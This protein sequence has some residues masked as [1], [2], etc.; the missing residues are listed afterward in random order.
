MIDLNLITERQLMEMEVGLLQY[1]YIRSHFDLGDNEDFREVFT[2]FYLSSQGKMRQED[3]RNPFFEKLFNTEPNQNLIELVQYLYD[4]L[5]LSMYE[6]SFATKLLHTI[7]NNSPIYDSKVYEYLKREEDVDF[8]DIQSSRRKKNGRLMNKLERIEH[9]WNEL[10]EWYGSFLQSP[11]GREW[12]N[13]F[14]EHFP[15][16]SHINNVKKIDF[17]IFSCSGY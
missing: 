12:I 1:E 5:A 9:N 14:D 3:N 8:I 10:N 15:R 6:F 2:N 17:I 11:R 16:Y 13:Y 4:H 7:N